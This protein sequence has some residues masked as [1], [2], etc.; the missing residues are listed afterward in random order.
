[1]KK[2]LQIIGLTGSYASGKSTV[3]EFFRR[4]GAEIIDADLLAR[5][6]VQAGSAGLEQ[7]TKAFGTE[8]LQGDGSLD[9]KKLAGIIFNDPL[10][11]EKLEAIIHPKVRDLF[12]SKLEASKKKL[13]N[14]GLIIYVVPLLFESKNKYLELEKVLVVASPREFSINRIMQRDSCARDLAE[15][16]YD[17]QM[18]PEEK[19]CKADF[20][21]NN[22]SGLEHLETQVGELFSRLSSN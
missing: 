2:T 13:A 15:K 8:I 7:V 10:S 11:K 1:M 18:P 6:V 5:E 17:S 12:L 3:A 22:T 14:G 9:R 16:K 20:V 4:L 19:I 21:I